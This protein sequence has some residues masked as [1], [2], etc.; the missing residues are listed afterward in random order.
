MHFTKKRM[1]PTAYTLSGSPLQTVSKYKYLGI[2]LTPS[3]CWHRDADFITEKACEVLGFLRRNTKLFPQQARDILY[4]S[5]ARPIL[6]YGCTVWDPSTSTDHAQ[7]E[8]VQNIAARYVSGG[9]DRNLSITGTK[10][11]L[12]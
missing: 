5:Y 8:T 1:P 3:M 7:L 6:G 11:T 10:E 9:Y 4:K 2:F 12:K